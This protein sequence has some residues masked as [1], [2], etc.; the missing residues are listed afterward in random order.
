MAKRDRASRSSH[1]PGGQGPSRFRKT[2]ETS[3]SEAAYVT[4]G[5]PDVD[6]DAAVETVESGYT[7]MAIDETAPATTKSRRTR[8]PT[9]ARADSLQVRAAAEDSFVR[10]DL[11]R[12]SVVS[13]IL[14]IG[15]AVA[16][17][18]FYA[19]DLLGLY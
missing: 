5:S 1:R 9:K 16:W 8:R 13:V 19:M 15:L 14:I 4:D 3:A 6:I 12:I 2:G 7:E 18:L 10:E 17:V 11:R